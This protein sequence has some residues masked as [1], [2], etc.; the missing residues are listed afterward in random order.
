MAEQ[1][2][3]NLG[4]NQRLCPECGQTVNKAA[5]VCVH[6]G[7][8]LT[9]EAP[10]GTG[11]V[12]RSGTGLEPNVAAA[13]S[14]VL[15]WVTGLIFLLIEKDDEYVRF[16]AKQAIVFGVA[17]FAIWIAVSIF[18]TVMA[19]IPFIGG[20]VVGVLGTLIWLV[21]GIGFLISWI[22]LIVKAYQGQ[23]YN[24]PILGDLVK[25]WG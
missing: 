14:Y 9:P 15:T 10:V 21:F 13:L 6:C 5:V 2:G 1:S 24:L 8:P 16:H 4:E 12:V 20:I 11:P 3:P 19:L 17:I 25:N 22:V 7:V 18:F 23:R